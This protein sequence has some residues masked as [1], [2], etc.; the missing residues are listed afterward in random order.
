MYGEALQGPNGKPIQQMHIYTPQ[1]SLLD[2]ETI[3]ERIYV[4]K[5]DSGIHE[6]KVIVIGGRQ[7]YKRSIGQI[8]QVVHLKSREFCWLAYFLC[9]DF[10]DQF[11][12]KKQLRTLIQYDPDVTHH[13]IMKIQ[14]PDDLLYMENYIDEHKDNWPNTT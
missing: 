6:E 9:G 7:Q 13:N 3:G 11:E 12:Y 1:M 14:W 8:G 5:E 2:V 10:G 4:V